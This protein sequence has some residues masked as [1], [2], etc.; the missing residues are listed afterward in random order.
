MHGD[1]IVRMSQEN[2]VV[3]GVFEGTFGAVRDQEVAGSNPV[4]PTD[5]RL[6]RALERAL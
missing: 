1:R 3:R 2:T 4:S 6:A 5:L